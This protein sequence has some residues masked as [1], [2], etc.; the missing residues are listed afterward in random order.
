MT[1]R[2]GLRRKE[3]VSFRT[4]SAIEI[5]RQN[6]KKKILLDVV[7]SERPFVYSM[8]PPA[9]PERLAN[10]LQKFRKTVIFLKQKFNLQVESLF[11]YK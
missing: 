3:Q 1:D 9:M 5:L 11:A 7:I 8:T 10:I 4:G 2:E 6:P